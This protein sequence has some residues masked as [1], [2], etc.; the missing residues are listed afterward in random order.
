MEQHDNG[1]SRRSFLTAALATVPVAALVV[2]TGDAAHAQGGPDTFSRPQGG[3]STQDSTR[4]EAREDLSYDDNVDEGLVHK[5][6][7]R[8]SHRRRNFGHRRRSFGHGFGHRRRSF[9]NSYV[10]GQRGF[11]FKPRRKS[12]IKKRLKFKKLHGF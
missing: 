1:M 2:A 5:A 7:F 9:D 3:Q 8:S 6:G 10:H 12:V 11:G 4:N